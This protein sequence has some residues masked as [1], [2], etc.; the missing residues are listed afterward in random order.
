MERDY[1]RRGFAEFIGAFALTFV[2]AG[3][4]MTTGGRDNVAIALAHGLVIAV[5]VSALGHISGGHFNP[6][7]TF[8]FMVTRR[9]SS[10]LAGVYWLAQF[11]GAVIAALLLWWIY[12]P[13]AI[14]PEHLGS[15]ALNSLIG[16][17][18]GAFVEGVGTFFLVLVVFATAAD[19][20]GT[21]KS[22]A[23][24]PIGFTIALGA[25]AFGPLT[26]AA[27][28]PSR[29]FGP[30]L[31]NNAWSSHAWIWLVGP[32]VGGALAAMTYDWFY[33]RPSRPVPVG[34]PE[35]GLEEPRPGQTAAS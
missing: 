24:L 1:L 3:V 19:P 31:V 30:I 12:P 20:R 7:V 29:A 25:L 4:V 17:G 18:P 23:G 8:G 9:M 21:F 32:M 33:L 34:P 22:V 2:G 15:P 10:A 16:S 28:N 26:G 13:Q 6:A 14:N 11:G 27:F 35:T 5:F